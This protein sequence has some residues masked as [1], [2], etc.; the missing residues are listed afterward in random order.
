LNSKVFINSI[1]I[2][3]TGVIGYTVAG[4]LITMIGKRKL[5]GKTIKQFESNEEIPNN[6]IYKITLRI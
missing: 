2:A 3:V 5:M 4:S 1:V 6:F